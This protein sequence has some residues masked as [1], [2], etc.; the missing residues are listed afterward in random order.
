ML[1]IHKGV[2]SLPVYER[3]DL[4]SQMRRASKSC[5]TNIAEGWAKRRFVKEFKHQL[6]SAIGSANEME[7][8]ID[9]AKD[10]GYWSADFAQDL[11]TRYRQLGGRLNNLQKN[12]T[13]F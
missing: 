7:V 2:V 6:D 13:T 12:W 5:P 1:I 10:L 8:H 4:A 9:I 11:A 3:H